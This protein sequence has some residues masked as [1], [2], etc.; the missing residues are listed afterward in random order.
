MQHGESLAF[1]LRLV[2]GREGL[3]E[4]AQGEKGVVVVEIKVDERLHVYR[5]RNERREG[6]V[7]W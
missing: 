7:V 6:G 3:C 5:G 1:A 2:L 4:C